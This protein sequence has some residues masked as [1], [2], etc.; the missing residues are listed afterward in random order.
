MS[1]HLLRLLVVVFVVL[2]VSAPATVR[3]QDEQGDELDEEFELFEDEQIIYSAAK[4][5][6]K[7]S[8]SPSAITVITAEQIRDSHCNTI[9]CLL[10]QVPEVE[11]RRVLPFY[12]AVG[13]RALAGELSDK[14]LV[15][16]DGR[17]I[18]IEL[19]GLVSWGGMPV[20][21][22]E[23]ERIEVIRG[24]GSALYGA[25]A[26]SLVVTIT[27]R[28]A[29]RSGAQVFAGAGEH[30][31]LDVFARADG[32]W[33]GWRLSGTVTNKRA[34]KWRLPSEYEGRVTT[35]RLVL[36]HQGD[37]STTRLDLGYSWDELV[38]YTSLLPTWWRPLHL[39][40]AMLEH[41]RGP[42]QGR[43]TFNMMRGAMRPGV[44]L[45]YQ[46]MKLGSLPDFSYFNPSLDAELQ[47][48]W[49]PF[50]GNL[51]VAG[52]NY[53]WIAMYADNN[54]PDVEH[55]H[56]VGVFLQDE[57]RLFDR[58]LLTAGI[59]LDYNSITPF[60][61][62]PRGAVV[63]HVADNQQLRLA[64][65]QAFRKP[66]FLNTSFH[67][68]GITPDPAFPEVEQFFRDNIGN[69]DLGNESITT[70]EIGYRGGFFGGK[71]QVE[72]DAFFN[73]YRDTIAFNTD[74]VTS[75]L[76]LPDLANS[77][78]RFENQG[79]DVDTLGGSLSLV[80]RP[81]EGLR[82]FANYTYRYSWYISDPLSA[83]ANEEAGKGDRVSWEPAHLANLGG[84]WRLENGLA[85][86]LSLRYSSA[87]RNNQH[88]E[89][90]LFGP[91]VYLDNP[92]QLVV[93]CWLSWAFELQERGLEVGIRVFDIFN[94]GFRDLVAVGRPDG[95]LVGG[96]LLGRRVVFFLR[97]RL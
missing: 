11:V 12:H 50:A 87:R 10:R 55:Q 13:A 8:D 66:S 24:P 70:V 48:D 22:E 14:A 31:W 82:L 80:A 60:T 90:E 96:E 28:R 78:M 32:V 88:Q 72:A 73:M 34:S 19:L 56:R 49:S 7:I 37:D 46:G 38:V 77:T 1:L 42:L 75:S 83:G 3:A 51:L 17:E 97:G 36:E 25:N 2:G 30:G 5:E 33:G 58:L 81:R 61:V 39:G 92:A 44:D 53:R 76:G 95:Y 85:A 23:I 9:A 21:L 45:T 64:A 63:W 65:G 6:Q 93:N 26:H 35:T 29:E 94:A 41:R 52:A 91:M 47:L 20:H 62:S 86:G 40:H 43:V 69:R 57:Q 59:R 89:G 74:I 54:T 68:T 16:V 18:N 15:L 67:L 27:T 4:H 84:S 71:L 79:R